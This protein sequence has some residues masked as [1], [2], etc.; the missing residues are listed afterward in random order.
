MLLET[1]IR[2]NK[3]NPEEF[4]KF[5]YEK[6]SD[7]DAI[8]IEEI[9]GIIESFKN[10]SRRNSPL[11]NSRIETIYIVPCILIPE[12]ELT[13]LPNVK[14]KITQPEVILGTLFIAPYPLYTLITL[15]LE[16]KVKR[17]YPDFEWLWKTLRTQF[18][19]ICFPPL[20]PKPKTPKL[21]DAYL[22]R[23]RNFLYKSLNALLRI[24]EIR[25]SSIFIDFLKQESTGPL[26]KQH[27]SVK[28]PTRV[29][30]T[31]SLAGAQSCDLEEKQQY[32]QI[33]MDY[34]MPSEQI[35]R[36]L[37]KLSKRVIE[38]TKDLSDSLKSL[39]VLLKG[40][41]EVEAAIPYN[42]NT[43]LYRI[44][45]NFTAQW[46][47]RELE[48]R[49]PLYRYFNVFFKYDTAQTS[50]LRELL[51][52]RNNAFESHLRQLERSTQSSECR[53]FFAFLNTRTL[54]E[55]EKT[56]SHTLT[57][58]CENFIEFAKEEGIS[59]TEWVASWAIFKEKLLHLSRKV[60]N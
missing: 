12:C 33:I 49:S 46:S 25:S 40:A 60:S 14:I 2:E 59:N 8:S 6:V 45:S 56:L 1:E 41:S 4:N 54:W 10:T 58:S 11:R 55:I 35:K 50:E 44:L 9:K 42:S 38:N 34:A 39:S 17:K 47:E 32:T 31:R 15:P 30:Q 26:K 21:N 27:K 18:P 48:L 22:A 23:H 16:W 19:G 7:L 20:P 52:M 57:E 29:E 53:D 28:K 36:R 43:E 3:F 5:F 13:N 24:P 37:I 51:E